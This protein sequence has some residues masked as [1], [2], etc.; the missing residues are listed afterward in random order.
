MTETDRG[1]ADFYRGS[2]EYPDLSDDQ[3][4]RL[5]AYGEPRPVAV[6]DIV[7]LVGDATYNLVWVDE[8][9]VELIRPASRNDPEEVVFTVGPG[10]FLGELGLLTGQA[11]FL[12]ARVAEAG[13]VL[14]ISPARFRQLMDEDPE[15]SD[16]LLRA[17]IARR[18]IIRAGPAARAIEIIGSGMSAGAM[19]TAAGLGATSGMPGGQI[20]HFIERLLS[21]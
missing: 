1:S 16:L 19:A 14:E 4:R 12:T 17:L 8:G 13:Q 20:A 11:V 3:V 7:F 21:S 5:R 2:D 10:N 18:K 9:V 15:L 6:G